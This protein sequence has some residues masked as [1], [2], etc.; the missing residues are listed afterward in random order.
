M[1]CCRICSSV[2]GGSFLGGNSFCRKLMC[3]LLLVKALFLSCFM[4]NVIM[5][6]RGLFY[7]IDTRK[8]KIHRKTKK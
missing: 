8:K 7:N 5:K 6:L 4:D 2:G 1:I 3:V